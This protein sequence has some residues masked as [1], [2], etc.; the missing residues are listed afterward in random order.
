MNAANREQPNV[1]KGYT[2]SELTESGLWDEAEL[3]ALECR[4]EYRLESPFV[5]DQCRRRKARDRSSEAYK[6]FGSVSA[7]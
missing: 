3:G 4:S 6:L 2:N 1:E 5:L 7:A